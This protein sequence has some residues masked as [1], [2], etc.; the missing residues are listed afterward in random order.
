MVWLLM[1][2]A[3]ACRPARFLA[4]KRS[5]FPAGPIQIFKPVGRG[6]LARNVKDDVMI[7]QE[8]LNLVTVNGAAGGPMPFLKM[9][10]IC[11]PKTQG[12][13]DR[14][15]QVQLK[16]FDGVIEPARKTID[17]LNEI[18]GPVTEELFQARVRAATPIVG[19]AIL[20]ALA[21]LEAVIGGLPSQAD[22]ST[23]AIDRL[24]RHFRLN[25][26]S[27]AEQDTTRKALFQTFTKFSTMILQ[28]ETLAVDVDTPFSLLDEFDLDP[29]LRRFALTQPLGFQKRG[30]EVEGRALDRI[31][32][33][34]AF[35]GPTVTPEFAAFIILHELCHFVGTAAG[36]DID[37][38]GRGWFDEQFIVPLSVQKRLVNADSYTTFAFECRSGSKVKPPF[39]R[40]SPG[41][42]GGAR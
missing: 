39:V 19:Q 7:I 12:A 26:L 11:G 27:T 31:H 23:L 4:P 14:F 17:K 1:P 15:Q 16:I 10:G 8:A 42:L 29:E 20:A 34:L 21:N 35:F 25:T 2:T 22:L 33:G 38:H 24:K 30:Q 9:D 41:G 13:I 40:S 37:D 28:P 3:G 32:L 18:I 6:P 36:E 5:G